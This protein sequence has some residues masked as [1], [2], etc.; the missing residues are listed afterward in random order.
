[1]LLATLVA[2]FTALRAYKLPYY[3]LLLYFMCRHISNL[4]QL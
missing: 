1:M 4:K 2:T 3:Y